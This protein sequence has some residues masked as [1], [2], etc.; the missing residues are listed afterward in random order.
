MDRKRKRKLWVDCPSVWKLLTFWLAGELRELN[1]R[2]WNGEK[3]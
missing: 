2:A 1:S 3:G